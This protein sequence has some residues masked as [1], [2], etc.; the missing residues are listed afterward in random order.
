MAAEPAVKRAIAFFD[1]QNLYR[2]ANRFHR[3]RESI[4]V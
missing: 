3:K 2:H 4:C 1:G